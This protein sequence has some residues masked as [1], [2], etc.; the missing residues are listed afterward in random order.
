VT[1]QINQVYVE[2]LMNKLLNKEV[3]LIFANE[4]Q[5]I[6]A[7]KEK[8]AIKLEGILKEF[9]DVFSKDLLPGLLL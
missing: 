3:F 4:V 7:R 8:F 1:I 5:T 6:K 9:Q 2:E